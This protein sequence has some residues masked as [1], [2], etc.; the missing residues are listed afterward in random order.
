[1][2][3]LSTIPLAVPNIGPED[4]ESVNVA[5]TDGWVSSVGPDVPAFEQA[6]ASASGTSSAV[7]VAS[8]TAALMI[9]LRALGIGRGDLVLCP[10]YTFIATANAITA[11]GADPIFVDI[12]PATWA[13][14]VNHAEQLITRLVAAGLPKPR[15]MIVVYPMGNPIDMTDVRVLA[16]RHGLRIVADA[17]AAIGSTFDDR[18]IGG[19]ADAT[20]FS[21]NGNKTITTGGGGAIVGE[22]YVVAAA[23]SLATTG[24][25]GVNYDHDRPAFNERMTNIEAALGRS[26]IARLESFIAAKARIRARHDH[27]ALKHGLQVFPRHRLAQRGDW[28]SGVVLRPE[29]DIRALVSVLNARGIGARL[30]W[31]PMHLQDGY[32]PLLRW[33]AHAGLSTKGAY[34]VADGLWQR[35]LPLPCSTNITD[36]QIDK[37]HAVLADA[38]AE[39]N[40]SL[41]NVAAIA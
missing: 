10:T 25:L 28:F 21:F 29:T 3:N 14:D 22:D 33:L 30:F 36:R 32:A 38:L 34:A 40:S 35:V 24:R 23:R 11:A 17:A 4:I 7:A 27:F 12:D 19:L 37:V 5:M 41:A 8:G 1:M 26:Q 39:N 20:T 6:V 18:P 13:I 9:A 31:K 16:G 15:A 2:Q